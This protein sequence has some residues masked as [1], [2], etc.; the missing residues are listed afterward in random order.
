MILL[1]FE[2]SIYVLFYLTIVSPNHNNVFSI[3]PCTFF[4]SSR[5]TSPFRMLAFNIHPYSYTTDRSERVFYQKPNKANARN[6]P[7]CRLNS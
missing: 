3:Q 2:P 1:F 4:N 7:N 5:L 6:T